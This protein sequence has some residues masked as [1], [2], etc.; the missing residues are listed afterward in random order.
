MRPGG[1]SSCH[2]VLIPTSHAPCFLRVL[3]ELTYS[4]HVL[5]RINLESASCLPLIKSSHTTPSARLPVIPDSIPTAFHSDP[6]VKVH[7]SAA[8]LSGDSSVPKIRLY[9]GCL[10]IDLAHLP[11]FLGRSLP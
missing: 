2:L 11:C 7:S 1:S 3:N 5:S 8:A 6:L 4:S 10:T 9:K